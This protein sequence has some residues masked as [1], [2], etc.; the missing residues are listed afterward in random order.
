MDLTSLRYFRAI[1][2]EG[3]ITAA[4]RQLGVSQP[5]LSVAVRNLETELSTRLLTRTR[6]GVELTATGRVLAARAEVILGEVDDAVRHVRGL[7]DDEMGSFT[8]GCQ[9]SLGAYFLP[10]FLA[11]FFDEAPAI[12]L[13][14][15]NA[16]SAEVRQA[17]IDRSI[18]F[19]LV[20]NCEPH[21]D[22]VMTPLFRDAVQ[23]WR[24]AGGDV[25]ATG[26]AGLEGARSVLERRP[27]VWCERPVFA[28]LVERIQALGI[29]P[30]RALVCKDLE[31]VKCLVLEGIGVGI[32]PGR[33]A[34]YGGHDRLR[35]VSPALPRLDDTIHLVYR[36][37]LHRTRAARRLRDALLERGRELDG[38]WSPADHA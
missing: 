12:G 36:G 18:D 2:R 28:G 27:L 9:E 23:L 24:V 37:D 14:L 35:V 29:R 34:R 22:L 20:V 25:R 16:S 7:Q 1:A 10:A 26:T 3:S 19:G 30:A 31:L 8:L 15:H 17:V 5:T 6:A 33:V 21:D 4:S 32:L 38:E 13:E 11:R